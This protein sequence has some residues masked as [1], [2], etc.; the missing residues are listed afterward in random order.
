MP[1]K[2]RYTYAPARALPR[3]E[4]DATGFVRVMNRLMLLVAGL[5]AVG[6]WGAAMCPNTLGPIHLVY[7]LEAVVMSF[8]LYGFALL[9]R[10]R[11]GTGLYTGLGWLLVL[12]NGALLGV[13]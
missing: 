1:K 3:D 11:A 5:L 12:A 9:H 8:W 7:L 2:Q 4:I 13:I 10:S 6:A